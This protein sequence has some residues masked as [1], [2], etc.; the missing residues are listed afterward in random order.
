MSIRRPRRPKPILKHVAFL[1]AMRSVPTTSA[2]Y[3]ALHAALL[4]L[5]LFDAWSTVGAVVVSAD[6]PALR[7]TRAAVDAAPEDPDLQHALSRVVDGIA[8]LG[9]PGASALLPR[10][11]A[12]AT[13][14]RER[15]V[16]MLADDVSAIVD[17]VASGAHAR[18]SA[19]VEVMA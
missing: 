15:G 17:G 14:Y 8:M 6:A 16:S 7:A 1:E 13:L 9:E 10:L 3:R 4:T 11:T 2:E 18:I 19:P 12:L 5:R